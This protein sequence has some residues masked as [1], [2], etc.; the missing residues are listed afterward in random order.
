MAITE[1]VQKRVKHTVAQ[2]IVVTASALTA[3]TLSL[4]TGRPADALQ[5]FPV[6]LGDYPTDP[7]GP[8]LGADLPVTDTFGN[9]IDV[10][11]LWT[12]DTDGFSVLGPSLPGGLTG[13]LTE[14]GGTI[15]Q[16][17]HDPASQDDEVELT[18]NFG[19]EVEQARLIVVDVD[20]DN[21]NTW[22][23]EI[24]VGGSV[25]PSTITP[26]SSAS[27]DFISSDEVDA[28]LGTIPLGI[29]LANGGPVETPAANYT[30]DIQGTNFVGVYAPRALDN[31]LLNS[32]E[33]P[34][35]EF[36]PDDA[37]TTGGV[38]VNPE[39][40]LPN[41]ANQ[42]GN[43]G[44]EADN[45]ETEGTIVVDY[46]AANGALTEL[47]FTYGNGPASV[48]DAF[49]PAGTD[50]YIDDAGDNGG[51]ALHG[52]GLYTIFV[53]PGSIGTAKSAST[54]VQIS[55]TEFE[56]TYTVSVENFG[57]STTLTD[58]QVLDDL[59]Q[60]FNG[61]DGV[62]VSSAPE[63]IS[64]PATIQPNAGFTGDGTPGQNLLA[65]GGSL[66]PGESAV[67]EYT[68][69][70]D[71]TAANINVDEVY[72][73][74]A[75]AEGTT[76]IGLRIFDTSVDDTVPPDANP[77]PDPDPDGNNDPT[78]QSPTPITLALEPRINVSEQ[79]EGTPEIA[80]ADGT[81]GTGGE[82]TARVTYRIRVENTGPERLDQVSLTNDFTPTFDN[83]TGGTSGPDN[84]F[85]IVSVTQV[86]GVDNAPNANYD[87]GDTVDSGVGPDTNNSTLLNGGV[88]EPGEFTEYLIVVDVDTTNNGE[89]LT[90][91][92]PG[93]F[94]NSTTATGVGAD[95]VNPSDRP[96]VDL[97]NDGTGLDDLGDALNPAG[98][99]V[100]GGS[101][102][103]APG[104]AP[105][106]LVP[107]LPAPGDPANENTPT[108]VTLTTAPQ[109]NVSEQVVE[110]VIDPDGIYGD[111]TGRV[112][113]IIRVEN[114]G[115]EDLT[116]V[117]L[118]NDFT[119]TFD[120]GTG[121]TSGPDNGF[122]IVSLE[123][124]GGV[125]NP[126]NPDYD[127]GDT[128]A[129]GAGANA[130]DPELI[131][132]GAL[133]VGEFSEYQIVVNVDLTNNGETLNNPLPGPFDNFTT[134]NGRGVNSDIPVS[135][136][137]N[138]AT[139]IELEE[140]LNPPGGDPLGGGTAGAPGAANAPAP[141]PA[142]PENT[143]TPV[144]FETQPLINVSEEVVST[145]VNP[146]NGTY[147][148]D[149]G[150]VTY[151]IRVQNT[152]V[153][154]LDTV[155]LT[156]DFTETF[157]DGSRGGS[158]PD[159]GFEIISL[160]QVDGVDTLLINP[161]YDGGD[162][163]EDGNDP[164]G[165]NDD[166]ELIQPAGSSLAV[167]AFVE[168][169][170]VVDV[171]LA[172]DGATLTTSI[173]GTFLNSTTTTG[174]GVDSRIPVSDISNDATGFTLEEALNPNND[175]SDGGAEVG[176]PNQNPAALNPD[177][178]D[179]DNT[180]TPVTLTIDPQI[181]V[182]QEVIDSEVAPTDGAFGDDTGRVTYLIRVQNT[183]AEDLRDVTLINDFTETFDDGSRGGSGPDNGFELVS[184]TQVDGVD[185]PANPN[186]DGG[187]S[188][189]TNDVGPPNT[190]DNVLLSGGDLNVGEFSEYIVV[191]DVNLADNGETLS[192][193]LPGP[194]ENSTL[195]T[196][197][198]DDPDNPSNIP[199]SDRSNDRNSVSPLPPNL[200]GALIPTDGS[201]TGGGIIGEPG[202]NPLTLDPGITDPANTP[203]PVLFGSDLRLV[204][205]ITG[206]TRGGSPLPIDGINGFNDQGDTADDNNLFNLTN[207][208]LPLGVFEVDT[209]LQSGDIVEYTIYFFNEGISP[210]ANV[211]IC[212]ELQVPSIL[213]PNSLELALPTPFGNGL[214]S[215]FGA[216]NLL[217][218]QAP[219]APLV[220]SCLSF[221][222]NFPSG[223]PAGG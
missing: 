168:Y 97:S 120:N 8:V 41:N 36:T 44:V 158:G 30:V 65:P 133:A 217:V 92:I 127:G 146:T 90:T 69:T 191:V 73:N 148:A 63:V 117:T 72:N 64:G 108:P 106:E 182:A 128:S 54:P 28:I 207:G 102:V 74:T 187:D 33:P 202:V 114:T 107:Q 112:T 212:D 23:D 183:G 132:P 216:S 110:T 4:T 27:P 5:I 215:S 122:E 222:G 126:I 145:E 98:N 174:I 160:D 211:A 144:E 167:G 87:G 68:V 223:V 194:F 70:L 96:V 3:A 93:T 142:D 220:E 67:I 11:L 84:G 39:D 172:N 164:N 115:E 111:N 19:A 79:V 151:R 184:V 152:G 46:S 121:G 124:V 38:L 77:N 186:Y 15:L 157:D 80:P 193:P 149:T 20:R 169:E 185:N 206:V 100:T 71:T 161:D 104:Q 76:P 208:S 12:G 75:I 66:Q 190:D 192:Q 86:D 197:I 7:N 21:A 25:A 42:P 165:P 62:S 136:I 130:N 150:R 47:T 26:A 138:D 13:G 81:F 153:E 58:V 53:V 85:E 205:R 177:E 170:I 135:D 49:N 99:S 32:T 88:L 59:N 116:D 40:P 94:N 125:D 89:T 188:D 163:S 2:K 178:D 210:A 221:P 83:G 131:E 141:D 78:E 219:L 17:N 118:T 198:G 105:G 113:Y 103:G 180:P 48:P 14:L 181:N 156:N 10:N 129:E 119:E 195:A 6:D 179:P 154:D 91:T 61:I 199:V 9:T 147:G 37:T 34:R 159:N 209:Q 166:A 22:Q 50:G 60:T 173:P 82:D 24:T 123:Q 175:S 203:T 35:T 139:G 43:L 56:V 134:T 204:K 155:T 200:E 95:P 214:N 51:P 196:G 189:D 171:N 52:V 16:I 29:G 218:P 143:P 201:P 109:I 18:I 55:A 1:Q 45:Q 162:S 31:R 101:L 57:T 176:N 137:S 213:Q 140:A